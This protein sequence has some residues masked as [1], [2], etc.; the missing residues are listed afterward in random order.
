MFWVWPPGLRESSRARFCA[1]SNRLD[2]NCRPLAFVVT[3]LY[4]ALAADPRR[5]TIGFLDDINLIVFGRIIKG[6]YRQL[7]AA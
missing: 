1:L 3:P 6:N 2:P 5:L 7:E 4:E